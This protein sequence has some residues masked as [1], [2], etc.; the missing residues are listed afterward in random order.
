MKKMIKGTYKYPDEGR[1]RIIDCDG[2]YI[3]SIASD[4]AGAFVTYEYDAA[5][6]TREEVEKELRKYDFWT[7]VNRYR[8][9]CVYRVCVEA[10]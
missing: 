5:C 3:I 1:Y 7:I 9:Q 10:L 8:E 2:Y 4:K 6:G